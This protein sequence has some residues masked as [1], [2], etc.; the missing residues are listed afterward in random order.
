MSNLTIALLATSG[1]VLVVYAFRNTIMRAVASFLVSKDTDNGNCDAIVLMNGNISTRPFCAAG[2]YQKYRVPVLL[3]RL[4]DTEEVR[5]GVIPNISEAT[6]ALLVKRDVP[7]GDIYLLKSERW[8]AGTWG[9]AILLCAHIRE[10]NYRKVVIVT[11]A[12]HT[13]RA[14][15]TFRKVM[16]DDE[17]EFSCAATPYTLGIANQWWRSEYGLVQV[18]VEYLKFFHYRRLARSGKHNPTPQES[19]LPMASEIRP[20]VLGQPDSGQ[21]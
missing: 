12:F 6:R 5:L 13:R 8:V 19:D 1:L 21:K 11:D 2:L 9:E 14:I 20:L 4:A 7:A 17:V 15:W 3:A 18:L 10:N 16:Q